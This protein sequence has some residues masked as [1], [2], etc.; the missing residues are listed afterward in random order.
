MTYNPNQV[1]FDVT[2]FGAKGD[3]AT[4]DTDAIQAA[5]D[6]ASV[7]IQGETGTVYFPRTQTIQS[8]KI[9]KPLFVQKSGISLVG[10]NYNS[11]TIKLDG[12][13]STLLAITPNGTV[14]GTDPVTVPALIGTGNAMRYIQ[15]SGPNQ[16]QYFDLRDNIAF[17]LNGTSGIS[18]E[19]VIN[20]ISTVIDT[21]IIYNHSGIDQF[22]PAVITESGLSLYLTT[23]SGDGYAT[24][25]GS[26]TTNN[27]TYQV[28]LA[29]AVTKN[30][31]TCVQ[32]SWDGSNLRV[33]AGLPG[34]LTTSASIAAPGTLV[35]KYYEGAWIGCGFSEA[36]PAFIPED[37]VFDGYVDSFRISNFARNIS[38]YVTQT[39]K[40]ATGN[41]GNVNVGGAG[42]NTI[43]LC[44]FETYR[45]SWKA[46]T[47]NSISGEIFWYIV[48][49]V[50]KG[51]G[52][53]GGSSY[54]S[55]KNLGLICPEGRAL[56]II[57]TQ[58]NTLENVSLIGRYGV[59]YEIDC[60]YNKIRN[61]DIYDGIVPSGT[62]PANIS[63]LCASGGSINIDI[64]NLFISSGAIYPIYLHGSTSAKSIGLAVNGFCFVPVMIVQDFSFATSSI[65]S[66]LFDSEDVA[67]FPGYPTNKGNWITG[68][69]LSS[70][71]SIKFTSCLVDVSLSNDIPV[72]KGPVQ[73]A[74]IDGTVVFDACSFAQA[75]TS[76]SPVFS[77]P[78][79]SEPI[80]PINLRQ[81]KWANTLIQP[82][83]SKSV[84]VDMPD[85]VVVVSVSSTVSS[86][87]KNIFVDCSISPI[88]ITL[89]QFP[90]ISEVH[91]I[92][93][94]NGHATINNITINGNG[95]N[96]DN[97]ISYIINTDFQSISIVFN[98]TSWSI[99]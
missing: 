65:D 29:D 63:K 90:F 83:Q 94:I 68:I 62:Y 67:L 78:V 98:G 32:L 34:T 80:Q 52:F 19:C 40:F 31:T 96:I 14:A 7:G 76:T 41:G 75:G 54:T 11:A 39:D 57:G 35:Q 25:V 50:G 37:D 12:S 20:Y 9:T 16:T 3:G 42:N 86:F 4:D 88:T 56:Q 33:F 24:L 71:G 21:H 58:H 82:S 77:I 38:D 17:D 23:G 70:I 66:M 93:D 69:G 84:A 1:I 74:N 28:A 73:V 53:I 22:S 6:A 87:I 27:G 79:G 10:E 46:Y 49:R 8:Y 15:G 13:P 61:V 51:G 45:G 60:Y 55:V 48:N 81:T 30:V 85:S 64:N 2:K 91:N 59:S 92:K 95:H 26:I 47:Y 36:W 44:N 18:V 5:I 97:E 72:V 99:V 89:P 43:F